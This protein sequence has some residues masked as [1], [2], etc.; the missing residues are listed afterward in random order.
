MNAGII[1]VAIFALIDLFMLIATLAWF[2][3]WS[4]LAFG[5]TSGI[6]F[7]QAIETFHEDKYDDGFHNIRNKD[8]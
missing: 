4:M 3:A 2:N 7:V 5:F 8:R 1:L 6:L